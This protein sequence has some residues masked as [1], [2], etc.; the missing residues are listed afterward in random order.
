MRSFLKLSNIILNIKLI[1]KIVMKNSKCA[2]YIS[3]KPINT[4]L[5]NKN[6]S[7]YIPN[8]KIEICKYSNFNDYSAVKRWIS[9]SGKDLIVKNDSDDE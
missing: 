2:I 1:D 5:I 9:G 6:E 7:S 3:N 4:F 8:T